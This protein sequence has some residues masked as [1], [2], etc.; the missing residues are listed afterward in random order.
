MKASYAVIAALI[1]AVPAIVPA[2]PLTPELQKKIQ[3][4]T[5]EVVLKK[6]QKDPLTYEKPLPL[7]LLP[8]AE[9]TD[10]YWSLGTA[11][12]IA[13]DTFATAAHVMD[14]AVSG[15]FGPPSIRAGDGKVYPIDKVVKFA[16]REDFAVFTVSDAPPAA[17][18][19]VN[20][21]PVINDAIFAVGNAL[22]EGVVIRDGLLTSQTPEQQDGAWK[23]L[24]FS[25]AASPG[26][27]GGPLLDAQGRVLGIVVAK[28]PNE[29]L[30]YASPIELLL[31][32]SDKAAILDRRESF[33]LPPI[34]QGTIVAEFKD[35][36][37]L[38]APY[39]KFAAGF[40]AALIRFYK[41][42]TA[43]LLASQADQLFPHGASAKLLATLYE[44]S[45]PSLVEQQEDRTWDAVSCP[46][47]TE[48]PLPGDGRV[49]YCA[50]LGLFRLQYAVGTVDPHRYGDSK[51]FM[52]MLLKGA[53]VPRTVGVQNVRITSLGTA[54]QDEQL[55]DRFGRVWQLR[56]WPLMFSDL[57]AET[58]GLPTPDGYVGVLMVIPGVMLDAFKEQLRFVA[59]YL[60]VSYDGS[61]PQWR[62]FLDRHELRPT[63]FD[64]IKLEYEF[65]KGLRF[66][67]PQL[68][69]DTNGVL[70]VGP[71]SSL[72]LRMAY[73]MDHGGLTWGVGG[74]SINQ[75]RDGKTYLAVLRQPKPGEDAGKEARE[76]WEHMSKRD[77]DFSGAPGHD[78]QYKTFWIRTVAGG[79]QPSDTAVSHPLYEVV[80]NTDRS[81]LPRDMEDI[82]AKLIKYLRVTE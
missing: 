53:Q 59:D 33:A 40:R 29:N 63:V 17:A 50:S 30:N 18:F 6:P 27:S 73:M 31:K 7:E 39:E 19:E 8:Y 49:W 24:R 9:R 25:A 5:F 46:N 28:S 3:A 10:A 78:D 77:G 48:T 14:A 34:L 71:K 26:N 60:Y 45:D 68:Q 57:Y 16:L 42:S 23:W 76:R 65:G 51:D 44:S 72:E 4:A 81:V 12:A 1:A 62:A 32:G 13:P 55:R 80:Y 70:T 66:D 38:P 2:A 79:E 74:V 54:Q 36:V 11:F 41:D 35:T 47:S 82:Q 64:R 69:L 75:D 22:G 61:L 37:P 15:Q 58:L 21:S 43:K 56:S 20:T 52:D 67:S